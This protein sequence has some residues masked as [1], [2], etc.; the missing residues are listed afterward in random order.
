M[1]INPS[2][3]ILPTL[4]ALSVATNFAQTAFAETEKTPA[5]ETNT[6]VTT[7]VEP[8]AMEASKT[9][10]WS[11][12]MPP[13]AR[14]R[15]DIDA[16]DEDILGVVKSLLRGLNGQN[17][18]GM[19]SPLNSAGLLPGTPPVEGQPAAAAANRFSDT[20]LGS[21]LR[22]ITHLRIVFFETALPPSSTSV[23]KKPAFT[24]Q[25]LM[26][27]Y[28]KRFVTE[29]GGRRIVRADFDDTQMLMVGFGKSGCAIVMQAPG[30]GVVIRTDGYPDLEGIGPLVAAAFSSFG[31]M[32]QSMAPLL[33]QNGLNLN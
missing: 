24:P 21:L 20:D 13:N 28:E 12:G 17:L 6:P 23:K 27:Y 16:R 5:P 25:P 8:A 29:A 2:G 9:D 19:M 7:V 15:L 4:L 14:L 1:K 31:P 11:V 30:K 22:N 10:D 18:Q 3:R 33:Q 32:L 26:S